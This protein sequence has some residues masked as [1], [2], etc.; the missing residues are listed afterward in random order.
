MGEVYRARDELLDRD[1]AIK[2]LPAASFDDQ[3]ARARLIREARAAAA[4]NHPHICTV[5]EVGETGGE[6]YIAME[7]IEGQPLS[8]VLT[9]ALPVDLVVRYG[10]QLADALA[11]AHSRGVVHRDL[12]AA[13]VMLTRDGRI[14]VLD[15]GLATR[16]T[17]SAL[18]ITQSHNALTQPGMVV[19]TLPYMA[20]EQLKGSPAQT[21]TDVWALGVVLYEMAAGA[22]PF[23]GHTG[24]EL[25]AAILSQPPPPLQG[26]PMPL[27]STVE[28]CLEKE[29]AQRY[30]SGGEV[31]AALEAI[32]THG[33]S[34]PLLTR[35]QVI[36]MG[37]AAAVTLAAGLAAW[38]F[39]PFGAPRRSLAVLPFQNALADD[40]INYLCAGIT[41]SLIQLVSALPALKVVPLST[42]LNLE[43]KAVDPRATG[44]E[45]R[46]DA[47]V[48][49]TLARQGGRLLVTAELLEVASGLSL[50]R[51]KYDFDGKELL[52]VQGEIARSIM[53]DGLRLKLTSEEQQLVRNPTNDG[54]A[55]DLYLQAR[56]L[57]RRATEEDYLAARELLRRA[58]VRDAQFALA[59]VAIG[60]IYAMMAADGLE[61]PNDAWPLANRYA[62]QAL[63]VDPNL[64]EAH[65]ITHAQAFFF[66]WDWE[67]AERERR[68]LLR[69]HQGE[70]DAQFLRALALERWALGRP[71]EAV[72]LARRARELDP[73]SPNLAML[74]A[75]YLGHAGQLDAA[76]A[77]YQKSIQDDPADPNPYF[78][79]S[80]VLSLQKRF[81]D[82]IVERRKAHEAA[83]DLELRD[84]LSAAR[85]E[86]GYR[87]LHRK[88][89][90][91]Q[92]EGLTA[93]AAANYVSPLD[94]ARAY[95]QLGD[96][97]RAFRFI[98]ASFIDRSPGLVFLKVDRA[99]DGI[100]D[101]ERF[102]A[103][104]LRVGL[105]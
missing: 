17:E 28:R 53:D 62:R 30:Q 19:G 26:V 50:W 29:P 104:V 9:M 69:S 23:A 76:G 22:R 67:G 54:E 12:K 64:P 97:D 59:H 34:L 101:D 86:R 38:R 46:V 93:R 43:G 16:L 92:L 68:A 7:L 3:M 61:R 81:D 15:F 20:P 102:A 90:Q 51:N 56:H 88:W 83:G 63:A 35:R 73:L 39:W 84:F 99:W 10:I 6:T 78:G 65:V 79:L 40:N 32:H 33:V 80:E 18:S 55:Y 57:Q 45:L 66:D 49:G 8:D 103:A 100:R 71:D 14:K 74:E 105:P 98:D 36:W 87:D 82:A 4:L 96:R 27:R 70:I 42:V 94:F 60:G 13:N 31:R 95:A 21:A 24:F 37:G 44:R 72:L 77:L 85:G 2:V 48:A 41:E 11:H 58:I 75:D 47:I 5:Y 91:V 1:V 25:S 52:R 89:V